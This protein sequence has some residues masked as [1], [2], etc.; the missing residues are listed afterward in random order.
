LALLMELLD[1]A[2]LNG[3]SLDERIH[4]LRG[5]PASLLAGIGFYRFGKEAGYALPLL[6]GQ[7][8]GQRL[9]IVGHADGYAFH[10]IR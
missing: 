10:D 9:H 5:L 6:L 1:S 3:R 2:G 4:A 8:F 7:F